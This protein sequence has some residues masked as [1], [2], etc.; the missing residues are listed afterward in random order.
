MKRLFC[1]LACLLILGAAP[2]L[3]VDWTWDQHTDTRVLGYNFY[4]KETGTTTPVFNKNIPGIDSIV[5]TVPDLNL[6]PNVAYDF[7]VT[8]YSSTAESNPSEVV[9]YTRDVQL[10][11]P[12]ADNL[13]TE[14]FPVDAPGQTQNFRRSI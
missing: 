12:P 13:P 8:A 3:A 9:Q 5:Y 7:W 6:K 11:T 14:E 4:W 2:A 1:L 10:Y